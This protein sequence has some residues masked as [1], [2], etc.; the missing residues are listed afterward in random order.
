MTGPQRLAVVFVLPLCAWC[1][2]LLAAHWSAE[3]C[4]VPTGRGRICGCREP[5][6]DHPDRPHLDPD[7]QEDCAA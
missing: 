4:Q 2:H 3:G 1:R 7:D 5:P 6:P